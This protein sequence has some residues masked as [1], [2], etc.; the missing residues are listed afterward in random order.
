VYTSCFGF[1]P[2]WASAVGMR[3]YK[4]LAEIER[5]FR[6]MKSIDLHVQPIYHRL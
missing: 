3:G 1:E 4:A 2:Q 6:P 5:A